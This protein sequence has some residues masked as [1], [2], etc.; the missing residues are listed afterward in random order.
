MSGRSRK[1][2]T[3]S[4]RGLRGTVYQRGGRWAYMVDLEPDPLTGK[5]R[6]RSKSGFDTEQAAWDALAVVN[7]QLRSRTYVEPSRRTVEEFLTEW[8]VAIQASVKP[9]TFAKYATYARAYVIP[10]IGARPLQDVDTAVVNALYRH[11]LVSGRARPDTN[12]VMYQRWLSASRSGEHL[13]SAALAAHAGVTRSAAANAIRRY[14]AGRIPSA[15]TGGLKPQAVASVHVMLRRALRDAVTWRYIAD[16]PAASASP[17]RAE[18]NPHNTWTPAQ[19]AAFL[20][21][22]R[23]DRLYAMW[24]LFATTGMRRS[25]VVG[26]QRSALDLEAGTLRLVTTHVTADG[27]MQRSTGKSQRSRRLISLDAVTVAALRKYAG[28]LDEER[29]M[30]GSDYQDHGL[31]FCWPDGRPIYPDTVTEQFGRLLSEAGLPVIRLHDLRHTYATMALRAGVNPKIV[32]SRLGH[33]TV[34]FT[35]DVYTADIPELDRDAAERIA[36]LFLPPPD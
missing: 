14:R 11:L 20:Q 12:S 30:W 2:R 9:T 5:R 24:L 33:A 34:A 15:E 23:N 32:S 6:Q 21:H 31:L 36:G 35:L 27:R 10:S 13:T 19:L 1:K 4:T 8:L 29:A 3:S 25:E 26:A 18:K 16:N 17:P 7:A 22:V 28:A